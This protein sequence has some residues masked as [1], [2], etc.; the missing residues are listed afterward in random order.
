MSS[1]LT[2]SL[3]DLILSRAKGMRGFSCCQHHSGLDALRGI[4]QEAGVVNGRL[5]WFLVH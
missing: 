1:D 4:W 3:T 5:A 2:Y